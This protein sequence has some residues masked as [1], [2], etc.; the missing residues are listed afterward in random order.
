MVGLS[1]LLLNN[2]V[3]Y[4]E[5]KYFQMNVWNDVFLQ[6]TQHLTIFQQDQGQQHEAW[7]GGGVTWGPHT[8]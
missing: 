2:I 3:I 7:G 4:R 8:R 6:P 1:C 5:T